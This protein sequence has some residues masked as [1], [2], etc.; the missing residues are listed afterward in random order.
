MTIFAEVPYRDCP[1]CGTKNVAMTVCWSNGCVPGTS[2]Y[3]SWTT[4]T[5]PRCAGA[6]LVEL[7]VGGGVSPGHPIQTMAN[8]REILAIPRSEDTGQSIRH[9]PDD[10]AEFFAGAQRVLDAGV[11]DAAAVQLRKT[12][13]AAA[14]HKEVK[15]KSLYASVEKLIEL[16][17]ITKDFAKLLDHVRKIGNLGAHY[18]DDRIGLQEVQR[19]MRFTTQVLRNLFEVPGELSELGLDSPAP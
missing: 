3:R 19:S 13:E 4:L 7:E 14:A 18:T 5:C 17:F 6:I 16:G 9:L 2:A 8:V 1:W 15:E 10:V 12:L 11:P